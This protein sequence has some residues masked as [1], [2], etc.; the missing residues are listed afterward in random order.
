MANTNKKDRVFD[1]S[2]LDY[3]LMGYAKRRDIRIWI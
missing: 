2:F 3:Y 1:F